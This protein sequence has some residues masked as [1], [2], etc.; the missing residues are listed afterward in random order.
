MAESSTIHVDI[1]SA[2]G[3]LFSGAAAVVSVISPIPPLKA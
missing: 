1:V 3:E 2:E